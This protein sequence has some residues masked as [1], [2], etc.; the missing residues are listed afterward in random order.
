MTA[1]ELRAI[2]HRLEKTQDEMADALGLSPS[3]YK[4]FEHG[5]REIRGPVVKL[6]RILALDKK[7]LE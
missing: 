4:K 1:E 5:H 3:G 6:A 7:N 2:R